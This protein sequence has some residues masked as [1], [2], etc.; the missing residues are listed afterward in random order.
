M[1]NGAGD[2]KL[3]LFMSS[4]RSN[5]RGS[6]C[7]ES[8]G[9]GGPGHRCRRRSIDDHPSRFASARSR[10][11]QHSRG[12]VRSRGSVFEDTTVLSLPVL[13]PPEIRLPTP[14]ADLPPV[15][16]PA[17][18]LDDSTF[19]KGLETLVA[20]PALTPPALTQPAVSPVSSA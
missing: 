17:R 14:D 19:L 20:Q 2:D 10:T 6:G 1:D 4:L 18:E 12:S 15:P 5:R 9:E 3:A 7:S 8:C 13:A 11:S 16:P